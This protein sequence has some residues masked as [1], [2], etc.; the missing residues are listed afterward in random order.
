[1]VAVLFDHTLVSFAA[2]LVGVFSQR[3]VTHQILALQVF[4][5]YL[6][7]SRFADYREY[8]QGLN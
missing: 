3:Q 1:M 5:C 6:S 4:Q 2:A 8:D 7:L